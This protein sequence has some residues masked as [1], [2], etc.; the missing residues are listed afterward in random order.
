MRLGQLLTSL[1]E[2]CLTRNHID[3]VILRHSQMNQYQLNVDSASSYL[4]VVRQGLMEVS[5]VRMRGTIRV[6]PPVA[7]LVET[8]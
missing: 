2:L 4:A 6:L 8:K 1:P 7:G 5:S 3:S